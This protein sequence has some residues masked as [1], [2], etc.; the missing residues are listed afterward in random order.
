MHI[1]KILLSLLFVFDVSYGE[2][3]EIVA[4]YGDFNIKQSDYAWTEDQK[5]HLFGSKEYPESYI[6]DK[7]KR[8]ETRAFVSLI[9][10]KIIDNLF[11]SGT[12]S[13]PEERIS[14]K[15][16]ELV[17]AAYGNKGFSTDKYK[18]QIERNKILYE[19]MTIWYTDKDKAEALCTDKYGHVISDK[20]WNTCKEFYKN[21]DDLKKLEPF[22][23]VPDDIERSVMDVH[24]GMAADV[25]KNEILKE[26]LSQKGISYHDWLIDELAN[27][28][29]LQQEGFS[30]DLLDFYFPRLKK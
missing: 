7:V 28:N 13:I 30:Q 1:V 17:K 21:P 8:E 2:E 22:L 23:E 27:V 5:K 10:T 19:L 29:F 6:A 20:S 14:K 24:K 12:L 26:Y 16:E 25:I 3:F 4:V 18:E 9:E 11:T 15:V